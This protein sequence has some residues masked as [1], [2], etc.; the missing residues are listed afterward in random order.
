MEPQK[1][2]TENNDTTLDKHGFQYA[3]TF[4]GNNHLKNKKFCINLHKTA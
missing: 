1:T 2:I 3:V 4:S